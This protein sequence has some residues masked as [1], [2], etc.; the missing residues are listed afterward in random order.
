MTTP[1][2]LK[3]ERDKAIRE[4]A[5]L[6]RAVFPDS[7]FKKSNKTYVDQC[8]AAT[9]RRFIV[10][11]GASAD[12]VG[13]EGLD[14]EERK[15]VT[16]SADTLN[17][18]TANGPTISNDEVELDVPNLGIRVNTRILDDCP[19]V[20]PM[21]IR[22]AEQGFRFYWD[23]FSYKP[24]L[25]TPDG[26]TIRCSYEKGGVPM[27]PAVID[28]DSEA[29]TRKP[30]SIDDIL[31]FEVCEDSAGE[32]FLDFSEAAFP[33]VGTLFCDEKFN[34]Q[35]ARF[36]LDRGF[37]FDLRCG[38]DLNKPSTKDE[39][40]VRLKKEK[41]ALVVASPNCAPFCLDE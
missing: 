19:D 41:P 36:G 4:A 22:Y 11:S 3:R 23:P 5:R 39:A 9:R 14:E 27:V 31:A 15:N 28:D 26:L 24:R 30:D 12:R 38:Y 13:R 20:L 34:E 29:G 16:R 40:R 7:E 25:V 32:E 10:D 17:I 21:G 8:A 1:W 33:S 18:S 2:I 37:A 35:C 6:H